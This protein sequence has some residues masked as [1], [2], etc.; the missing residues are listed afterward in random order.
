MTDLELD[1]IWLSTRIAACTVLVCLP[2]AVLA[3]SWA[4]R[5]RGPGRWMFD[6]L[7]LL[8]MSVSPVVVGWAVLRVFGAEGH[9]GAPVLNTPHWRPT[10]IPHGLILVASC[11]CLP[12]M[13]RVM[14]PAFE[15][16]DTG[17]V[18]T[19]RTLGASRWEAWWH[20][21]AAQARPAML[22]AVVLGFAAAWGESGA[23]LMLA[24]ALQGAGAQTDTAGTVPLALLKALQ[25]ESGQ[26]IGLR[27]CLMSL[28]VALTATLLSEWA[29]Q[30]WR[31]QALPLG[32]RGAAA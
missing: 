3:A 11:L 16:V 20:I 2:L 27:L 30:H 23:S 22:S 29:H 25:T 10:L 18:M 12:L 15:A 6:A 4:G 26:H 14:R 31:R 9:L 8:P 7:L 19:A 21:T 5:R 28:G 17:Q 32:T 13:V 24:S 1:A